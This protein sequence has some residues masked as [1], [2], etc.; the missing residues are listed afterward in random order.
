MSRNPVSAMPL[1]RALRS[2]GHKV[3]EDMILVLVKPKASAASTR[4]LP[5]SQRSHP[6]GETARSFL[7]I[8]ILGGTAIAIAVFGRPT[9]ALAAAV[10]VVALCALAQGRSVTRSTASVVRTLLRALQGTNAEVGA[11]PTHSAGDL[12]G[13]RPDRRRLPDKLSARQSARQRS[14]RRPGQSNYGNHP[15][16]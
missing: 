11:W 10:I 2:S 6:S 13:G 4:P 1:S 16:S 9:Q 12:L 15:T 14:S 7:Q 8:T 5:D 3:R